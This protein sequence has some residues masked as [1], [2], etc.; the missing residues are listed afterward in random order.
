[1]RSSN[2][3]TTREQVSDAAWFEQNP[4]A[5]MR[6]RAPLPGEFS[7]QELRP[8][9]NREPFVIVYPRQ[10]GLKRMLAWRIPPREFVGAST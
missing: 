6:A 7:P 10:D 4:E 2:P 9:P 5:R 1:M 3:K 8:R